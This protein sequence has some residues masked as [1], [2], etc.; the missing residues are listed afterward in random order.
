MHLQQ[1]GRDTRH[2]RTRNDATKDTRVQQC[3]GSFQRWVVASPGPVTRVNRP[4]ETIVTRNSMKCDGIRSVNTDMRDVNG[5]IRREMMQ[6][7]KE[8]SKKQV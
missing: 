1:L 5:E 3:L 4:Q 7:Q 6:T 2:R 8:A